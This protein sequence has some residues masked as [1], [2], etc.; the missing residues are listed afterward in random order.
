MSSNTNPPAGA[1]RHMSG[2]RQARASVPGRVRWRRFAI[3]FVPAAAISA[4]LLTATANG[5]LAASF[6]ISGQ[7]GETSATT[8]SGQGFQQFGTSDVTKGGTLIPVAESEIGSAQITNLC[9]S[10]VESLPLGLGDVTLTIKGGTGGT[11]VSASSLIIDANQLS[12]STATFGN[13]QEGIDAGSVSDAAGMSPGIAGNFAQQA[14][15]INISNLQE[16]A[17]ATSAGTLTLPGFSLSLTPGDSP[18]FAGGPV[19]TFNL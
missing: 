1:H 12:G 4:G 19:N 3:I 15:S 16:I 17:Y 5:A 8:L 18:C 14:T 7:Q 13:I 6:S 2:R 9:Q 10:L 11:P